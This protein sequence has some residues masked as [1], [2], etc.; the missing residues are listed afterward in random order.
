ML[1]TYAE[2]R[3]APGCRRVNSSLRDEQGAQQFISEA[4]TRNAAS[5]ENLE[6]EKHPVDDATN[7]ISLSR[8]LRRDRDIF[9]R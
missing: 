3:N 9:E 5:R 8:P 4:L 7:V 6:D 1:R 2:K